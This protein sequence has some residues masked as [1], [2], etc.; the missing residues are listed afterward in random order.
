MQI[1]SKNEDVH[2]PWKGYCE[3]KIKQLTTQLETFDTNF[4]HNGLE[5][6]PWAKGKTL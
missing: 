2:G 1:L 4:N 6:R 5:F 3:S